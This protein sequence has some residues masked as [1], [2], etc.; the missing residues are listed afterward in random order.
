MHDVQFIPVNAPADALCWQ[1]GN[2]IDPVNG[3]HW[4]SDGSL[5]PQAVLWGDPFDRVLQS[6]SGKYTILYTERG[7]NALVI[8]DNKCVRELHRSY[9]EAAHFDYP[10]A[11]GPCAD[12]NGG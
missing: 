5:G 2:L 1:S 12:A 8:A 10:I 4:N 6:P 11:T 7:T 3:M 9:Y